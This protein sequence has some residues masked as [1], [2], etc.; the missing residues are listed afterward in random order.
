[1]ETRPRE[2]TLDAT[3]IV[4]CDYVSIE[5]VWVAGGIRYG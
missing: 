5:E 2:I 1:M 3:E 4:M